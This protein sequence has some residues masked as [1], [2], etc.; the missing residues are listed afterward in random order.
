MRQVRVFK[1]GR[2][3]DVTD[4]LLRNYDLALAENGRLK[5]ELQERD[6]TID[7]L[8][9]CLHEAKDELRLRKATS[10]WQLLAPEED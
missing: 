2:G 5:A 3:S 6:K 9:K 10:P 1:P 4:W 8:S 7:W